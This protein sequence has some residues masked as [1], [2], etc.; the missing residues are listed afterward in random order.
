MG[1]IDLIDL[2]D[3][4]VE[5]TST[6][7]VNILGADS[8]AEKL[9]TLKPHWFEVKGTTVVNSN[10]PRVEGSA[11]PITVEQVLAAEK[12]GRKKGDLTQYREL[13]NQY[14]QQKAGQSRR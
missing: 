9:K 10:T 2:D 1:D 6:G 5:T 8:F 4:V 7:K 11:G 3:V 13:Y 12:E 14:R